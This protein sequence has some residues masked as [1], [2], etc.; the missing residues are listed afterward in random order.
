[1]GHPERD[2]KRDQHAA[3]VVEFVRPLFHAADYR[4]HARKREDAFTLPQIRREMSCNG[5]K[6]LKIKRA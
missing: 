2:D 5:A 4:M 1:M 6:S 3:D